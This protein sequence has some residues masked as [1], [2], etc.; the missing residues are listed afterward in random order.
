MNFYRRCANYLLT[1][2]QE[3]PGATSQHRPFQRR[4]PLPQLAKTV[5]GEIGGAAGN[6]PDGP[7]KKTATNL[8]ALDSGGD[9]VE[10]PQ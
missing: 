10:G 5:L 3:A 4:K 7:I 1:F 8:L 2:P 9:I 6:N